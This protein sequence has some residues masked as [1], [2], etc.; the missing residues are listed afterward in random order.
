[1]LEQA[2]G[3]MRRYDILIAGGGA[4]GLSLALQLA[5]S[6]LRDRAI[7][8][9]DRDAKDTDDRTWSFWTDRPTPYD[10]IVC[11]RWRRLKF[12]SGQCALTI[13]LGGYH[14]QMIRAIDFYRFARRTL[15]ERPNIA[16]LRGDIE[17]IDDGAEEARVIVNGETI[18]AAWVFDSLFSWSALRRQVAAFPCHCLL[19][20]FEGWEIET[21]EPAFDAQVAT[22]QDF[23]TPQRDGVE[24][25]YV[26]PLSSNRALVEYVLYT[27]EP[28]SLA[29]RESALRSYLGGALGLGTYHIVRRERGVTPLTDWRFPRRAG[30]RVM[31][32][33]VKGGRIKPSTGYA[34]TRMQE[35][36]AAIVRSLVSA[37]EPFRVA[38]SPWRYR[39]FDAALLDIIERHPERAIAI[40]TALYQRN[41]A[42]RLFRM[43]DERA[44]TWENLRMVP[45]LPAQLVLRAL[46][47][48]PALR[49]V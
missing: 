11:A 17:R 42:E 29:L 19:Q 49:H 21:L 35:D 41:T 12:A 39:F 26:L 36:A 9:V 13:D 24:F 32:L 33:G 25:L 37:G 31:T 23:R 28:V 8:I 46:A 10:E 6:P 15:A 5:Q 34:F 45:S 14:Y 22:F 3:H 38:P 43:L 27:A 30:R 4:A 47:R 2:A 7:L 40:F 44:S 1:M 48:A 16:F 20:Q 18:G